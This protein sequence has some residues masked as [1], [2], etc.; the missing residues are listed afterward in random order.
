MPIGPAAEA[1]PVTAAPT[2]HKQELCA[3]N[4]NA[5]VYRRTAPIRKH[6]GKIPLQRLQLGAQ[7]R[8]PGRRTATWKGC[9][10]EQRGR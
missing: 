9:R 8:N 1:I 7:R 10:E 2:G 4:W 3:Q 6:A 5:H